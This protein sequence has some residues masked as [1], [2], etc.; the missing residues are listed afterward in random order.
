[1]NDLDPVDEEE[2]LKIA[3]A[4]SLQ[5]EEEEEL[6][7]NKGIDPKDIGLIDYNSKC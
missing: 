4:M 7:S 1:M 3:I 2:M 5:E 6:V